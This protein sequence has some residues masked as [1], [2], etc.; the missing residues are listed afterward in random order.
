MHP[1]HQ[2]T[3][4]TLVELAIVVTIIG[5][6]LTAVFKGQSMIRAGQVMDTIAIAKDISAASQIFKQRYHFLPGD[7][8]VDQEIL[9]L[10][11]DCA[12]TGVNKGNGNGFIS[13]T[14]SIC[15]PAQLI[16]AD[17]LKGNP[18]SSLTSRYGSI[19]VIGRTASHVTALPAKIQ[20]VMEF[21]NIPC[22]VAQEIDA[23][24]DDGNLVTGNV[25]ADSACTTTSTVGGTTVTIAHPYV[26]LAIP[27]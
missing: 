10:T 24:L 9:E 13:A 27:L 19:T 12:P 4:F 26:Y 3:G 15:V 6:L 2:R 22:D 11:G 23:K 20:N 25:Q 8:P 14:E 7:F 21:S 17:L 1:R 18:S 16:L 5:L